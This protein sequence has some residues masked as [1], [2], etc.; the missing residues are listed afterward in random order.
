MIIVKADIIDFF[1]K[2]A[3]IILSWFYDFIDFSDRSMS[4]EQS[5]NYNITTACTKTLGK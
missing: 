5:K 3:L 4:I 1:L 2:T